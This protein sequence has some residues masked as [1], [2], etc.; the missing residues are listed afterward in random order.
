MPILRY[1]VHGTVKEKTING[2]IYLDDNSSF[3]DNCHIY[4]VLA[5]DIHIGDS[6]NIVS[7]GHLS[8]GLAD[9]Y[10]YL[11]IDNDT[12]VHWRIEDTFRNYPDLP[13]PNINNLGMGE[14]VCNFLSYSM[15][16]LSLSTPKST[17]C[18]PS[19]PLA[20]DGVKVSI[21]ND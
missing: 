6:I 1:N 10:L 15:I 2:K 12:I 7:S 19:S 17:D 21:T 16:D 5:C 8:L 3:I 14:C 18:Q 4:N 20:P 13:P 11:N 9:F